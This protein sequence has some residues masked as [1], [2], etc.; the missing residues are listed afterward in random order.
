MLF[1]LSSSLC[2]FHIMNSIVRK[3][4]GLFVFDIERICRIVLKK[5]RDIGKPGS[6]AEAWW[7][8]FKNFHVINH[9]NHMH[10]R[11][12]LIW[13]P[14]INARIMT[15]MQN[16]IYNKKHIQIPWGSNPQ[17]VQTPIGSD[18]QLDPDPQLSKKHQIYSI[19][20]LGF[21]MQNK[22]AEMM[23]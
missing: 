1:R 18:P 5:V 20:N 3:S 14:H 4:L 22:D 17:L 8:N 23:Q 9:I 12:N 7:W 10:V 21:L 15:Y 13:K 19:P 6:H 16:T 11:S 2:I